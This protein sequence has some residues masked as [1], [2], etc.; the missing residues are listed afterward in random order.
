MAR[1]SEP[2]FRLFGLLVISHTASPSVLHIYFVFFFCCSPPLVPA[3]LQT[4]FSPRNIKLPF[5]EDPSMSCLLL[6]DRQSEVLPLSSASP[7][8]V[9]RSPASDASFFY[10]PS[11]IF[12]RTRRRS[13]SS[14]S[15]ECGSL[16][17]PFGL[18]FSFSPSKVSSRFS[19]SLRTSFYVKFLIV[20]SLLPLPSSTT[21]SQ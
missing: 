2:R 14:V 7:H 6:R 5:S 13:S 3:A 16:K 12:K 8:K 21:A 15:Y 4:G 17:W 11:T 19:T 9:F 10:L 1:R 20:V 18:I